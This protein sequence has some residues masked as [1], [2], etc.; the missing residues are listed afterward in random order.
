MKTALAS[1][2]PQF[3]ARRMVAEYRDRF[4]VPLAE[5]GRSADG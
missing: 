4:Y 3:S 1:L 2:T 5:N